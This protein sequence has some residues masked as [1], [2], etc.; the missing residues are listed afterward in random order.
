MLLCDACNKGY[1]LWCLTPVLSEVPEG[2]WLCP[3]CSGTGMQAAHAEVLTQESKTSRVLEDR[4]GMK[5]Q[6]LNEKLSSD[7]RLLPADAGPRR[8]VKGSRS[9]PWQILSFRDILQEE[10]DLFLHMPDQ[11]DWGKQDK[12]SKMVRIFM[13]GHWNEG[14]RTV[15]SKKY[16]EQ[17]AKARQLRNAPLVPALAEEEIEKRGELRHMTRAQVREASALQWGLELIITAPS[18]VRRLATEVDW[19]SID[20]VWDPW[21]GTGV[22]NEVMMEQWSHLRFMNNDWNS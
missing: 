3:R 14:R 9:Q 6:Q 10:K 16:R 21:A 19:K 22:I 20:G 13:P 5:E 1:H 11:V 8:V 15:L 7:M 18:E 4:L 2:E 17:K 12:L